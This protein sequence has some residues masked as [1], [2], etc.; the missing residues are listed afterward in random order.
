MT[1]VSALRETS[2]IVAAFLGTRLL[3]E[4]FGGRRIASACLVVAG[5]AMLQLS[6]Q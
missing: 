5:V 2:V 4:P 1:Y 6:S 3:R